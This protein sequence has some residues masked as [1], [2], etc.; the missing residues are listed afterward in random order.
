[1]LNIA[2]ISVL[3]L[4]IFPTSINTSKRNSSKINTSKNT[5]IVFGKKGRIELDL[6][7]AQP[8]SK[9]RNFNKGMKP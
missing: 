7:D 8:H 4:S 5:S 9:E 2:L 1:M 6:N 3:F